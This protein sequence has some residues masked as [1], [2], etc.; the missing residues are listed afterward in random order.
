MG[1]P[2]ASLYVSS[3]STIK[4]VPV[5]GPAGTSATLT[6]AAASASPRTGKRKGPNLV[7]YCCTSCPR[8]GSTHTLVGK[9]S[10]EALDV[11]AALSQREAPEELK[12]RPE[13]E[14]RG[15]SGR[16]CRGRG[17]RGEAEEGGGGEG[18]ATEEEDTGETRPPG[19]EIERSTDTE[20]ESPYSDS[21]LSENLAE[22]S[23]N[24]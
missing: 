8:G 7:M 20:P 24:G 18:D 19:E 10:G 12:P 14:S 9:S 5:R 4:A 1:S 15:R 6:K 13:K 22:A 21:E 3:D 17:G 2:R 23:A 11:R 16:G